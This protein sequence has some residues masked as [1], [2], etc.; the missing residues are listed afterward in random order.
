MDSAFFEN[1]LS[2][3]DLKKDLINSLKKKNEDSVKIVEICEK[4]FDLLKDAEKYTGEICSYSRGRYVY[5]FGYDKKSFLHTDKIYYFISKNASD[6]VIFKSKMLP[7]NRFDADKVRMLYMGRENHEIS[8]DIEK[9][10]LDKDFYK[11]VCE[12]IKN[13][14]FAFEKKHIRKSELVLG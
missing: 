12:A 3:D 1:S 4:I 7:G 2:D 9:L 11:K 6:M 13:R 8:D 5:L 10:I 14:N